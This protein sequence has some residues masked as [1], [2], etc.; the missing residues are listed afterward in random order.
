MSCQDD[1]EDIKTCNEIRSL[2]ANDKL[3]EWQIAW[4]GLFVTSLREIARRCLVF[5]L[6]VAY[7]YRSRAT[8]QTEHALVAQ[9]TETLGSLL[10][11]ELSGSQVYGFPMRPMPQLLKREIA[12]AAIV[13]FEKS[14]DSVSLVNDNDY[15]CSWGLKFMIGKVRR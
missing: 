3:A 7:R 1:L 14:I 2:E 4:G 6:C 13:C 12:G 5:A 10:Y 9:I 11:S 15:R 8:Q